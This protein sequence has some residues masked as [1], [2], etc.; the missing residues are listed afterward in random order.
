[1]LSSYVCAIGLG[2]YLMQLDDLSYAFASMV[3]L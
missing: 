3:L 1:M 2:A